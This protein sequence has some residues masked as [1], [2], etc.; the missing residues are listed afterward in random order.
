MRTPLKN[1]K[2]ELWSARMGGE[3]HVNIPTEH[4]RRGKRVKN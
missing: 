1:K 2:S 3:A 4:K